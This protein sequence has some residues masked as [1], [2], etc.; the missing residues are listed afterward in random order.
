MNHTNN[1]ENFKNTDSFTKKSEI[2]WEK[3]V[4]VYDSI[5]TIL[6]QFL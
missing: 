5:R 3:Y 4:G 1:E 6:R 2:N